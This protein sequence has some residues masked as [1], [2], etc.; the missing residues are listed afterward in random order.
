MA[1]S[2]APTNVIIQSLRDSRAA[3]AINSAEADDLSRQGVPIEVVEFLRW[4][5]LQSARW[6]TYPYPV[7][8]PFFVAPGIYYSRWGFGRYSRHPSAGINLR[9]GFRR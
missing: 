8:A 3:Y 7:Y 1:Q 4:G 9:F 2:G 6:T 5:E